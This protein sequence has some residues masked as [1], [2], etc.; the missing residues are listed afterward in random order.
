M[1]DAM[2]VYSLHLH[3]KLLFAKE[4]YLTTTPEWQGGTVR[5]REIRSGA[6]FETDDLI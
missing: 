4:Y 1:K 5:Q 3:K 2:K 6:G